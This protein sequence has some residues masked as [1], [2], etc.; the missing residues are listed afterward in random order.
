MFLYSVELSY[1]WKCF[2]RGSL[3]I[4][5]TAEYLYVQFKETETVVREWSACCLSST[6]CL[7]LL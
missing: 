3:H 6:M 4:E 7:L 1:E 5:D 2:Y